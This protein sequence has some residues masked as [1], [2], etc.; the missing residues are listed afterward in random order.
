[1]S[2]QNRT[3]LKNYFRTGK[4][5]TQEQFADLIDSSLNLA[6]SDLVE[7]DGN[8][9]LGYDRPLARLA[10]NG[11]LSVS[12]TNDDA[13]DNGLFVHGNVGLGAGFANPTAQLAV[14]GG[15]YIGDTAT[16]DPGPNGLR[17]D[18]EVTTGGNLTLDNNKYIATDRVRARD[19]SGL[20]LSEA[21][22]KGLTVKHSSGDLE[23][24]GHMTIANNRQLKTDKVQARDNG[25]LKLAKRDGAT[26]LKIHDDGRLSLGT[27]EKSSWAK[28]NVNGSVLAS[29]ILQAKT[30][31]LTGDVKETDI[32]GSKGGSKYGDW[33]ID[34]P[35]SK[36]VTGI[37]FERWRSS[38]GDKDFYKIALRYK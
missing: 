13:P 16:T 5:P 21:G 10:V 8:F 17:V 14:N 36:V 34:V 24:D 11:N 3:T 6:D 30:L 32:K 15:V 18:G 7:A 37:R 26:A 22:G 38:D 29:N 25:G 19:N 1:M 28:V 9:G 23:T 33:T 12:P 4:R 20:K 2:Q 31:K 35:D 27:D